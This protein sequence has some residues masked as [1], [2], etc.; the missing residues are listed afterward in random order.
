MLCKIISAGRPGGSLK[1]SLSE[2]LLGLSPRPGL[3]GEGPARMAGIR[4]LRSLPKR[5]YG[6]VD[7]DMEWDDPSQ[8]Q[9]DTPK[10]SGE[11]PIHTCCLL[12]TEV[13]IL[14]IATLSTLTEVSHSQEQH[15]SCNSGCLGM[16]ATPVC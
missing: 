4:T 14:A 10:S 12:P 11:R 8:D 3:R 15:T 9:G 7:H 1:R 16:S 5:K 2:T 13:H 6:V